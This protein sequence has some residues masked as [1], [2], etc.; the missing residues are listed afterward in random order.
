MSLVVLTFDDNWPRGLGGEAAGASALK[1]DGMAVEPFAREA[2]AAKTACRGEGEVISAARPRGGL[3][4]SMGKFGRATD[5]GLLDLA[6]D[7]L[8]VRLLP[9]LLLL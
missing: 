9:L 6:Y 4:D 7:C 2:G 5:N 8:E 1:V 3:R